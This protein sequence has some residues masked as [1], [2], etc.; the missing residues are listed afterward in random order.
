MKPS[1]Q[2]EHKLVT[3]VRVNSAIPPFICD[4]IHHQ[5]H[6]SIGSVSAEWVIKDLP[7][8]VENPLVSTDVVLANTHL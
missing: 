7:H 3:C 8:P 6:H 2:L 5:L 4:A 1:D